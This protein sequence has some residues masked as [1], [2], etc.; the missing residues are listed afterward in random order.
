MKELIEFSEFIEIEKKLE[1]KIGNIISVDDVP[2]SS[3]LIK[4]TVDFGTEK[5]TVVTNI[6]P[7]LN[8]DENIGLLKTILGESISL[9]D[10]KFAFITNLKPVTIMGIE[11]TAMILPGE[12]EKGLMISL[13]GG[14]GTKLL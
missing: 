2:K 8:V 3:K 10:K 7:F 11:S 5:R 6:K 14:I 13:K 1:I 4:L 9:V 12:I